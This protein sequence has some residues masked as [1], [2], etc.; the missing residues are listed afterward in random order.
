MKTNMSIFFIRKVYPKVIKKKYTQSHKI[1]HIKTGRRSLHLEEKMHRIVY[2][3]FSVT[4]YFKTSPTCQYMLTL[5][6]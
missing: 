5:L 3:H 2:A 1:Q 4:I 6:N